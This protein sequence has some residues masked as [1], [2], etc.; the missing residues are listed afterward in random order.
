MAGGGEPPSSRFGRDGSVTGLRARV[1]IGASGLRYELPVGGARVQ[2]DRQDAERGGV[3]SL[4]VRSDR[5]LERLKVTAAGS[6]H[7]LTDPSDGIEQAGGGLRCK[8]LVVV[9]VS[10]QQ[11]VGPRLVKRVEQRGG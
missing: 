4:G 11:Q 1:R 10:G 2:T 9:V 7:E 8:A 3:E 5:P 6:D